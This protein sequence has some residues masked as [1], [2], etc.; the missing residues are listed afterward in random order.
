MKKILSSL[1]VASMIA[2]MGVTSFALETSD[3]NPNMRVGD[4]GNTALMIEEDD[5]S[6]LETLYV[7]ETNGVDER[8]PYGNK[9]YYPLLTVEGT[10]THNEDGEPVGYVE[11]G[12]LVYDYDYVQG[13]SVRSSWEE[14]KEFVESVE[15]VKMKV[16][17]ANGFG[18]LAVEYKTGDYIQD[19]DGEDYKIY[20]VYSVGNTTGADGAGNDSSGVALVSSDLDEDEAENYYYF[21]EVDTKPQPTETDVSDLIGV[22]ELRK[23]HDENGIVGEEIEID[24]T[25]EL[26]YEESDDFMIGD[27]ETVLDFGDGNTEEWIDFE[28]SEYSYFI[29][30]T[31]DQDDIVA[32]VTA[33][34]NTEIGALEPDANMVFF[35]GNYAT[36]NR[37]GELTF[38]VGNSYYFDDE[39]YLYAVSNDGDIEFIADSSSDM[40]DEYE[41]AF[42]I[43]TRTL[44]TY[45]ISDT[46]LDLVEDTTPEAEVENPDEDIKENPSTGAKA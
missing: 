35:N 44:G 34:Y 13:I 31:C 8:I 21:V 19:A 42:K 14:G 43:N 30:D 10:E 16:E 15:I 41:E 46:E 40:Y 18:E 22:I 12:L 38:A 29:V 26:Q 27:T 9:F 25:V 32:K 11:G 45:F 6:E 39:M 24:V 17:D 33:T 23:S 36:F 1:L 7:Y 5:S 37:S 4:V 2:S 28:A 3:V 20:D